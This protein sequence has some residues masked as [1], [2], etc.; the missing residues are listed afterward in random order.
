M[1]YLNLFPII[2]LILKK[3]IYFSI[4]K[5]KKFELIYKDWSNLFLH[6]PNKNCDQSIFD[7]ILGI[8][9]CL[10]IPAYKF[11]YLLIHHYIV[12]VPVLMVNLSCQPVNIRRLIVVFLK[13]YLKILSIFKD[14]SQFL[15]A[16]F[17]KN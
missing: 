9:F 17:W 2:C 13:W 4:S 12:A 5:Q 14:W 11:W 7:G 3:L 6:E 10:E 15:F 8:E 1:G 16:L